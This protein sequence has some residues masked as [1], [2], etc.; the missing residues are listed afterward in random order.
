MSVV[1]RENLKILFVCSRNQWRSPTGENIYKGVPGIEALSAG[2][3]PSARIKLSLKHLQWADLVL[4]MEQKHK[5][6]IV[7][8]FGNEIDTN[9]ILVLDIPDEYNY[10]DTELVE[11]IKSKTEAFLEL[12]LR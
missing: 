2:T 11:E 3:E 5:E 10:M 12:Y 7:Q 8:K 4:V 1:L 6:K 9:K